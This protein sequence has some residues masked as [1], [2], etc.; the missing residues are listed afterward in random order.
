MRK[1]FRKMIIHP[2]ATKAVIIS[3]E[4]IWFAILDSTEEYPS[5]LWIFVLI[6]LLYS[7]LDFVLFIIR[8]FLLSG[9]YK[10]INQNTIPGNINWEEV[11]NFFA[12]TST[13]RTA[14]NYFDI[15][16]E[17]DYTSPE[18]SNAIDTGKL[19]ATSVHTL[20]CIHNDVREFQNSDTW[21]IDKGKSILTDDWH[22]CSAGFILKEMLYK[23]YGGLSDEA[24]K[25]IHESC[26]E[27]AIQKSITKAMQNLSNFYGMCKKIIGRN[28]DKN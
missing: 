4:A 16:D 10:K 12:N 3:A 26:R 17:C 24:V 22:Q 15:T 9:F 1:L 13:S 14:P 8:Q 5:M 23:K 11:N 2:F 25:K 6:A 28:K 27:K 19:S 18:I 7:A 20:I 21:L